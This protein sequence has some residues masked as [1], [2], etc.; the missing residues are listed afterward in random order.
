MPAFLQMPDEYMDIQ[1][2]YVVLVSHIIVEHFPAFASFKQC[3]PQHVPHEYLEVMS[4]KVVT[5]FVCS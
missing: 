2:N 3:G 1:N 4:G 5:E